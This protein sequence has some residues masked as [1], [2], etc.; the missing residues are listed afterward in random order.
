MLPLSWLSLVADRLGIFLFWCATEV[1]A[2]V[3]R[4][5]HW[6]FWGFHQQKYWQLECNASKK[7]ILHRGYPR[8]KSMCV[9]YSTAL[10]TLYSF[11][12]I[13]EYLIVDMNICINNPYICIFTL[14]WNCSWS[15]P[16]YLKRVTTSI[17]IVKL[18]GIIVT[19]NELHSYREFMWSTLRLRGNEHIQF[20]Y[21][22][23]RCLH[24]EYD[25]FPPILLSVD[26]FFLAHYPHCVLVVFN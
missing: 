2:R 19:Y 22:C 9:D 15:M 5:K 16:E 18:E 13:T 25:K 23:R 14:M 4:K 3:R 20:E 26:L 11:T 1:P 8:F 7:H 12:T 17:K 6:L 10:I 24:S 21:K